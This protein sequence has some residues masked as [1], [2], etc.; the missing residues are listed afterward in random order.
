MEF[1]H[2]SVVDFAWRFGDSIGEP[3]EEGEEREERREEDEVGEPVVV[4]VADPRPMRAK[5]N[6]VVRRREDE[7]GWW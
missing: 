7:Q 6:R 4:A 1:V 3:V 2:I 5:E